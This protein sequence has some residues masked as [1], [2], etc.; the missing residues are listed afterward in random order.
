MP[1]D[2]AN[3]TDAN[4]KNMLSG[5]TLQKPR[6]GVPAKHIESITVG[7]CD[8]FHLKIVVPAKDFRVDQAACDV[9][10]PCGELV[11]ETQHDDVGPVRIEA[12]RDFGP[13]SL[14][15]CS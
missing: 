7:F 2:T 10:H 8:G 5:V 4:A 14:G 6:H 1:I 12:E 11:V 13:S 15:G 3:G 9:H